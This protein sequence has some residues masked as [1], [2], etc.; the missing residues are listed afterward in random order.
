MPISM[1]ST[2]QM[3]D[4]GS[5]PER[6]ARADE[7]RGRPRVALVVTGFPDEKDPM[8]GVFN[9]RAARSLR[10][11]TD[12]RV[13]SLRAWLP[14]RPLVRDHDQDGIPVRTLTV[15][16]LPRG[17]VVNS[18]LCRTFG[19]P[20]GVSALRGCDLVH[21]VDAVPTGILGSAWA[22]RARVRHVVQVIGSDV[23]SLL[24]VVRDNPLIRGWED[25]VHGV[26]CNS[27]A[28]ADAFRAMYPRVRNV[29]TIYR[30][31]DVEGLRPEGPEAGPLAGRPP[32]RFLY[33]GGFQPYASLPHRSNTKG[34]ETLL[35]AWRL[36]E[37]ELAPLGASLL[38]AGPAADSPRVAM[39][40]A[41]L[42][43]PDRVELRGTVPPGEVPSYLRACEVVLVPSMEEGLPNLA[44]EAAACGRAV[45]GSDAGGTPEIVVDGATGLVLPRGN[46]SALRGALVDHA[47]RYAELRRMGSNARRRVVDHF[48]H[49]RYASGMTDL[50]REVLSGPIDP[51]G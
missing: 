20:A 39:W 49:G 25:F 34:G 47:G 37:A 10:D 50:Y 17:V 19:S 16:Q 7:G 42:E 1:E 5:D 40:R 26:A 18:V 2:D 21:T 22:R 35:E 27:R 11:L 48:D 13:I 33:L 15:P 4:R 28:L 43:H 14:S 8:R 31:V 29:R 23:N 32:A 30:G 41:G 24:P 46:V 3:A 12:L 6:E 44:L 9:L 36:A 51:P 45:F 38:V